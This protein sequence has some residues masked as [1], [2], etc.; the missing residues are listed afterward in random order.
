MS[1]GDIYTI[2]LLICLIVGLFYIRQLI[3]ELHGL[4]AAVK[5]GIVNVNVEKGA[6]VNNV[7]SM[8]ER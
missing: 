5:S 2:T 6:T 7:R 1:A 8:V 4:T 3:L